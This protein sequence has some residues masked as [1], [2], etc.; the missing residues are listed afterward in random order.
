MEHS[1]EECYVASYPGHVGGGKSLGTRLSAMMSL[2]CEKLLRYLQTFHFDSCSI[3]N[4]R[5]M[6][7]HHY[8]GIT[9]YISLQL[10]L[11]PWCLTPIWSNP[12]W[13]AK[14]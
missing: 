7:A 10:G 12:I 4:F 1:L 13:S 5:C 6:Y 14:V 3:I 2:Q 11:H 8:K 9:T